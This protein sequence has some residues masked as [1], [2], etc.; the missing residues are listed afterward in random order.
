MNESHLDLRRIFTP[1][2]TASPPRFQNIDLGS[3]P[4]GLESSLKMWGNAKPVQQGEFGC[5]TRSS[6]QGS[7]WGVHWWCALGVFTCRR[8]VRLCFWAGPPQSIWPRFAYGWSFSPHQFSYSTES[9]TTVSRSLICVWHV[10]VHH[11]DGSERPKLVSAL[12]LGFLCVS[13]LFS[14]GD[15]F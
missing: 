15:F 1:S 2:W 8:F 10:A 5:P 9:G 7:C 6:S 14:E 12:F 4:E 3:A 11:M 13:A